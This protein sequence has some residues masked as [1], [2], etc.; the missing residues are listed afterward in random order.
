MQKLITTKN[1]RVG[2]GPTST[3]QTM[4]V[5]LLLLISFFFG[6]GGEWLDW[7]AAF[8]VLSS[9]R[10]FRSCSISISSL[11]RVAP[12]LLGQLFHQRFMPF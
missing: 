11:K 4:E 1:N 8:V 5:N 10:G 7:S 3:L 12:N 9:Q 6:G 2:K